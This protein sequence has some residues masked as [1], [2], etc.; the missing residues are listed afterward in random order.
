MIQ[1]VV[2]DCFGVLCD[3]RG[4]RNESVVTFV[5]DMRQHQKTAL[6]S[7][8]SREFIAAT[9]PVDELAQLF[10]AVVI[11]SEAGIAKPNPLIYEK[12]AIKL[13]VLP[14]ECVM[15]DDSEVNVTGARRAGMQ[16]IYYQTLEQCREDL[17]KLLGETHA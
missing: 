3:Q 8:V 6:L 4:G 7:N 5:R 16:G 1:A 13:G 2:F 9:F 10:D 12:V 15:V 17:A 14:E 11:S